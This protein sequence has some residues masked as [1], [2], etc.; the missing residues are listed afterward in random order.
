MDC[1]SQLSSLKFNNVRE[2]RSK[3]MAG[4]YFPPKALTLI[5]HVLIVYCCHVFLSTVS[6]KARYSVEIFDGIF[7]LSSIVI[8]MAWAL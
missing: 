6:H 3:H 4:Q 1:P 7:S 5:L 8:C 2:I